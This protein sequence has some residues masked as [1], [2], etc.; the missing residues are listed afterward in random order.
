MT[1]LVTQYFFGTD[2]LVPESKRDVDAFRKGRGCLEDL[3]WKMTAIASGLAGS[4]CRVP[5]FT[6]V[7]D[8]SC[9]FSADRE[10]AGNPA[11]DQ[12]EGDF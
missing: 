3:R 9:A 2:A 6:D 5:G 10:D 4:L 11:P 7:F 8:R 1:G 12:R